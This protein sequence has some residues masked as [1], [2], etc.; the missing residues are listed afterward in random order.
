MEGQIEGDLGLGECEDSGRACHWI[1]SPSPAQAL[2]N[3][4]GCTVLCHRSAFLPVLSFYQRKPA[5]IT[6][7]CIAHSSSNSSGQVG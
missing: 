4:M 5:M 6:F 3:D 1:L 7:D 2:E